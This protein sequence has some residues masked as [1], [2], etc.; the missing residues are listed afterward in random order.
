MPRCHHLVGDELARPGAAEMAIEADTG[1]DSGIFQRCQPIGDIRAVGAEH[2]VMRCDPAGRGAVAALA[3]DPVA[4]LIA[5]TAQREGGIGGVAAEAG[6]CARSR[7]EAQRGGDL[8]GT[9]AGEH[10]KGAAVRSA[11]RRRLLPAPEL[12]L[13]HHLAIALGPAMAGRSGARCYTFVAGGARC[14]RRRRRRRRRF[15]KC[16]GQQQQCSECACPEQA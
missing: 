14:C 7:A 16:T 1:P 8:L 2:G 5:L 15:G 10:G 12:V 4:L 9:A 6:G 3:S 13:P 11:L